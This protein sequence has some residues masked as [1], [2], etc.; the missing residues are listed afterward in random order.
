[1]KINFRIDF[2]YQYLYSRRHYH[3]TY[4]WD[5]N[6]TVDKGSI[7]EAYKLDYPVIWF[8][9]GKSAKETK[10]DAPS[11]S[12]KTKRGLSGVRIVADVSEESVFSLRTQSVDLDFSCRDIID[13]GRL[14][15]PVGPKYLGCFVTVTKEDYLW[16][17]LPPR[18]GETVYEYSDLQLPVREHARG[19]FAYLA[20]R[21]GEVSVKYT[22]REKTKDYMETVFHIVAMA[23]ADD[24]A[25]GEST[26]CAL[27]PFE[28]YCDGK[29]VRSFERYYRHHDKFMQILEDEWQRL[30]L[31]PGEHTLTLKNLH[32]DVY[33]A[34]RNIILSDT[35]HAH[36]ELTL[37]E[38]CLVGEKMVGKVFAAR[39]E[40]IRID[41]AQKSI[42]LDCKAGYN[43]FDFSLNKGGVCRFSTPYSTAE[44]EA[45]DEREEDVPV[46]VGYDMTVVPHDA[47]GFMDSLLDYTAYTRLGNYVVFRSFSGE[48]KD[49]LKKKWA[50][51]CRDHGIYVSACTDFYDGTY[52]REAGEM[53]SDCGMHEYPGK[54]YAFDPTE[55]YVSEDMKT[56]AE[57]YMDFLKI[58]ID[59]THKVSPVAAFGDASGG[60][61]YSYLAGVDFVRAET[62]VGHTQTLL[63]QARPAAEALGD[64]RWGVHIAIQHAY[65]P[66]QPTHIG[67]Y[68][69]SLMQP[70][71]MGANTIYEEDCLFCLF[72][73][74]R[75]AWD[76]LLTKTKRDM[77]RDFFRFVKTHPRK[78]K[79]F[80]NIGFIE[81]RY[82]APFNGFICDVE[83]DPHYAVWGMFGNPAREWGHGQPEKCRQVLDVLMPGASTQPLR[84]K[85]DKRRFFFSG[86]P[87][88][89][90]DC[91]PIE[92]GADYMS[93]YKLLINFG[94]N[95]MIEEDYNKLKEYI[96]GG[97][98]LLTG[99]PQFS[100][101]IKRE[102]LSDMTDLS[103]YNGG[104]ISDI[105]GVRVRGRGD[106]YSGQFNAKDRYSLLMPELSSHP[107]DSI[108]EDGPVYLADAELCGAEVVA[109]D[110]ATGSPMLV[111]YNLG[112]GTVYTILTYAYP[113]HELLQQF[114]AAYLLKLAKEARGDI[115]VEDKSGEV[116]YTLWKTENSTRVYMLNTDW[117]RAH[118]E[119]EVTLVAF[120]KRY[121]MTVKE[122]TLLMA[123]IDG[124][125]N[126]ET[127][128]YTLPTSTI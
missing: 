58:E 12:F 106:L 118:N 125:G 111:K 89:D 92:A 122:G 5:G 11:W 31:S 96:K 95:S 73:E 53:F 57:K 70:W 90:F 25:N 71:I 103:L 119:K 3:P 108:E 61:R 67:Q 127:T 83:Q 91:L 105:A 38:W 55:P 27:M 65:Q 6:L 128:V 33:L 21:G 18:A 41:F 120:G 22:V 98:T 56:A 104:D 2:G 116:F 4:V 84:Q 80:R 26:V 123:E 46:K 47:N 101:H 85:F 76:D 94:W 69:L 115:Y 99:L 54:V 88:G 44:I 15:F 63:S 124:S 60:I 81:G 39:D 30:E 72:K 40:K 93:G 77:T 97:G 29:L 14:T 86:T 19:K 35:E 28:I 37:P 66:Y 13:K 74:E 42:I 45:V 49:E 59:K 51:F 17:R 64:G 62:M 68:F 75:Q 48:V 79:N 109:W 9:P 117:T 126:A 36:G 10:L 8:G 112:K 1:M 114:S 87:C 23:A 52:V 34:I 102:F 20:P 50:N 113:G 110:S 121:L 24:D 107:S 82:A 43:E 7:T 100:T 32:P 16:F 78:G